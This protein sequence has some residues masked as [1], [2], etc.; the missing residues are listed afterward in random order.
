MRF[1]E[2]EDDLRAVF[3][4]SKYRELVPFLSFSQY[5]PRS[6]RR[7]LDEDRRLQVA[8]RGALAIGGMFAGVIVY[9]IWR[10]SLVPVAVFTLVGLPLIRG[11]KRL[12]RRLFDVTSESSKFVELICFDRRCP[13][14]YLR[15]FATEDPPLPT[16]RTRH[17]LIDYLTR[18][19]GTQALENI[20][21]LLATCGPVVGVGRPSDA[22]ILHRIY[23]LFVLDDSWRA[24]VSPLLKQARL[25]FIQYEPSQSLDWEVSEALASS[26][27][28]VFLY[29]PGVSRDVALNKELALQ[30][31]SPSIR[32]AAEFEHVIRASDGLASDEYALLVTIGRGEQRIFG[33]KQ[34]FDDVWRA[35]F[36]E[37]IR[38]RLSVNRDFQDVPPDYVEF[39]DA[40]EG[41]GS[42]WLDLVILAAAALG[43]LLVLFH[44]RP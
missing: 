9:S 2:S 17:R 43:S 22:M 40:M 37:I 1:A 10:H 33:L 23:R 6:K 14:I 39:V 25:V 16:G 29:L 44:L 41:R 7:A 32:K 31:L 15:R 18:R 34:H 30:S 13:V 8:G 3:S 12:A 36:R 20:S 35:L 4:Q 5:F 26:D 27:A 38:R 24:V 21:D 11:L 42:A 19:R 28:T